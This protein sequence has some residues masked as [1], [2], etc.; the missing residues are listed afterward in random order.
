MRVAFFLAAMRTS[1]QYFTSFAVD[2]P[3]RAHPVIAERA[4]PPPSNAESR[5]QARAARAQELGTEL[6]TGEILLCPQEAPV[7]R[8]RAGTRF[9]PPPNR[10]VVDSAFVVMVVLPA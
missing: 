1:G 9:D 8:S 10:F 7:D 3:V 4:S 2:P 5:H 6:P